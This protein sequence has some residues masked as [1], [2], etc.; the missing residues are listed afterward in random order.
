[1]TLLNVSLI[2]TAITQAKISV[3]K[4]SIF[5]SWQCM[6]SAC[7]NPVDLVMVSHGDLWIVVELPT[8]NFFMGICFL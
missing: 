7:L 8:D 6:L 5:Q 1:M 3:A 2:Y 4:L